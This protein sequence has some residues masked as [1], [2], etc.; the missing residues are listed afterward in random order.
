MSKQVMSDSFADL[1]KDRMTMLSQSSSRIRE[2]ILEHYG[3]IPQAIQDE[4][5]WLL[6]ETQSNMEDLLAYVEERA[7]EVE[8]AKD[9]SAEGK[10]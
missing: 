10:Q 4:V 7:E 2:T 8:A 3:S 6:K 1:L 5:F 9:K